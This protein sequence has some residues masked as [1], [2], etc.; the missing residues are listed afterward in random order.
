MAVS[1]VRISWLMLARNSLLARVA[2]SA[3][4]RASISAS[5]TC[6][7]SV[8][9]II[10]PRSSIWP[11]AD[12]STLT[13]SS[14]QIRRPSAASRRYWKRWLRPARASLMPNSTVASRSSGCRCAA[15]KPG[16]SQSS[17]L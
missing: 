4:A 2:A 13:K 17:S 15:Q 6:L 14:T 8:M 10:T 11:L 12:F 5:A 1:G 7:A 3:F 9:S 16:T